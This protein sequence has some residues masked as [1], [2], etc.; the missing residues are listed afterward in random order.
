MKTILPFVLAAACTAMVC[1]AVAEEAATQA[2]TAERIQG[3]VRQLGSDDFKA[4]QA[5]QK[6]LSAIGIPAKSELEKVAKSEDMEVQETATALLANIARLE[7]EASIARRVIWSVTIKGGAMGDPVLVGKTLFVAGL[8]AVHAIDA[9]Q[10]KELWSIPAGKRP[11]FAASGGVLAM[12]EGKKLAAYDVVTGKAKWTFDG[13]GGSEP[14]VPSADGTAVYIA[15]WSGTFRAISTADGK[16][17]WKVDALVGPVAPVSLGKA[18]VLFGEPADPAAA[19]RLPAA[20]FI[21]SKVRGYDIANG[22]QTWEYDGDGPVLAVS[23]NTGTAYLLTMTNLLA[24]D[25]ADG[26]RK[27]EYEL[28]STVSMSL[29]RMFG[30]MTERFVAPVISGDNVFALV[31]KQLVSVCVKNCLDG[32]IT[33][34]TVLPGMGGT[35]FVV[36]GNIAYMQKTGSLTAIDLK[37]GRLIWSVSLPLAASGPPIVRDG[38]LYLALKASE[39]VVAPKDMES[40]KELKLQPGVHALKLK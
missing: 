5:A 26:K 14:I 1:P 31:D 3:L 8:D 22:K 9:E 21:R 33:Q 17:L 29:Q 27:W 16:E 24:L 12:V 30:G 34:D 10:G 35:D 40:S 6:E 15:D 37:A 25:A 39:A 28:S 11:K 2:V 19:R 38:T 7:A 23:A 13:F 20:R 4:R 36:E 18:I 32:K